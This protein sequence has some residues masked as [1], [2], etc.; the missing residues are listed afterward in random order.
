MF[1]FNQKP[2]IHC[3]GDQS[4]WSQIGV[5]CTRRIQDQIDV[6]KRIQLHRHGFPQVVRASQEF[7]KAKF[8]QFCSPLNIQFVAVAANHH[9][10]H[11]I[12]EKANWSSC[13]RVPMLALAE[14]RLRLIDLVITVFFYN[15]ASRVHKSSSFE[16]LF[17]R[18]LR[19]STVCN[20][21]KHRCIFSNT[22][23][24]RRRQLQAGLRSSTR[25]SPTINMGGSVYFWR[26]G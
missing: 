24:T 6:L 3:I 8:L 15:N 22:A 25:S 1:Y 21:D 26:D 14:P 19:I 4:K 18:V 5:L 20:S 7:N 2:F 13:E 9:G 23:E 17:D 16:L 10:G 12:V 11:A